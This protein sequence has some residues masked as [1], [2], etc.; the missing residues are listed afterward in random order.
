MKIGLA[1]RKPTMRSRGMTLVELLVAMVVLLVGIWTIAAGFPKLVQ[2]IHTEEQKTEMARFAERNMQR[3]HSEQGALPQAITGGPTINPYSEP[4]DLSDPNRPPNAMENVRRVVGE[5]FRIPG[6]Q[7]TADSRRSFS[8]YVLKQGPAMWEEGGVQTTHVYIRV[9][10]TQQRLDPRVTGNTMLPNSYY[11]DETTGEIVV[12]DTVT[13]SDGR[14]KTAW[15]LVEDV[16]G[17]DT[18]TAELLVNYAW[19]EDVAASRPPIHYVQNERAVVADH[20][21]DPGLV[22]F[23][24]RAANLTSGDHLFDRIVGGRTSVSA[25]IYFQREEF[26]DDLPDGRGRYVQDNDYGVLLKFHPEDAG[27]QACVD[28]HVRSVYDTNGAETGVDDALRRSR[29]KLLMMEDHVINSETTRTNEAGDRFTDVKLM[30]GNINTEVPTF[31]YQLEH[32]G[33][34]HETLSDLSLGDTHVLAVDLTTGE[35]YADWLNLQLVNTDLQPA[36]EEG[37]KDGIV[38]LPIGSGYDYV[39]HTLRF[40]YSTLDHHNIQVQK[41]PRTMVDLP[42]ARAYTADFSPNGV[43]YSDVVNY[44]TYEVVREISAITDMD[45]IRLEFKGLVDTGGGPEVVEAVNSRGFTLSVDYIWYDIDDNPHFV[46]GEMHKVPPETSRITLENLSYHRSD[47]SI[48]AEILAVRGVS[49][50][51]IVWWQGSGGDLRN[52]A[53]DSYTLQNPLSI[54]QRAR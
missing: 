21:S 7:P 37:Y 40:Y 32:E 47:A 31:E 23:S 39:G 45:R 34:T 44:R 20:T 28:Y 36:L 51:S 46:Y 41:P 43:D 14:L 52:V 18:V 5:S 16:G 15:D 26:G 50:R 11:V 1:Y 27:L 35:R 24:V 48:S 8:P 4:E 22:A 33:G 6:A 17:T 19:A 2:S 30:G 38:C 25:L 42:T 54:V 13:T 9:P 10:L 12:P 53:L 49:S 29:R 3:L